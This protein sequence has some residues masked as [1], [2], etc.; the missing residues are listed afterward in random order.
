MTDTHWENYLHRI[1]LSYLPVAMACIGVFLFL[2]TF[3]DVVFTN[4]QPPLWILLLNG[5]GLTAFIATYAL[6]GMEKLQASY[7]EIFLF[8]C[9]A[10]IC[11]RP[12]IIFWFDSTPA[13][14]V[15][16]SVMFATGLVFLSLP[17][18]LASQAFTILIYCVAILEHIFTPQY[19]VT[20]LVSLNTGVLGIWL[21]HTRQKQIR[22]NFELENRVEKLETIL[23]MCASCKQTR[24][25]EG[26]WMSIEEYLESQ[27]EAQIS[28][29]ICPGCKDDLYGDYLNKSPAERA[30]VVSHL[31]S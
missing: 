8:L 31:A 17:F 27:E 21:Q 22:H 1:Q 26:R 23:P 7:A 5:I 18:V 25:D 14:L 3:R 2:G 12:A 19:A 28:H 6:L 20:L 9:Y 30:E 10:V 24:D 13:S 16:P 29:A 11:A 15:L 4:F